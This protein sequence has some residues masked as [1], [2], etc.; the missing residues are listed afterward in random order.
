MYHKLSLSNLI[1][2][3]KVD[4]EVGF[5]RFFRNL[6]AKDGE[7]IRIFDRGDWYTAHGD[8]ASFIARTVEFEF[9]LASRWI[10]NSPKGVQNNFR[11]SATRKN[12]FWASI[13]DDD[14]Y[15]L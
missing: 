4:D 8:D 2:L 3:E 1:D 11:A 15:G 9:L 7:T 10:L 14:C 13:R 6:P 5:I 12:R